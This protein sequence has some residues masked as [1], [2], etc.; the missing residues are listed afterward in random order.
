MTQL[1]HYAVTSKDGQRLFW[2]GSATCKTDAIDR[3]K[4]GLINPDLAGILVA[5]EQDT[6]EYRAI[7]MMMAD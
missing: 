3:C 6:P 5:V 7:S 2:T 4:G 1:S